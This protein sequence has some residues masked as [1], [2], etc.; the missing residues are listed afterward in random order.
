MKRFIF[1]LLI[2]TINYLFFNCKGPVENNLSEEHV[3]VPPSLQSEMDSVSMVRL[4][5]KEIDELK[6]QTYAVTGN[7]QDYELSAPGVVFPSPEYSS[8]ISSPINGQISQINKREGEWVRKGE[9]LFNIQSLEFGSMVSD[10]LSA[11]AEEQY[12]TNNLERIQQLVK[13]TI[14]SASELE[15]AKAEYQRAVVSAKAAYSKLKAI[16]VSDMEIKSFTESE[17]IN[18]ILK[19]RSPISGIIQQNFVELGQSINALENLSRVLDTRKVLIRGY[20]NPNDARRVKQGDPVTIS[21]REEK[22][23]IIMGT[24]A[25]VNPGLDE[26]SKSVI[27]NIYTSTEDGWP[28]PGENVHLD[29]KTSSEIEIII[30]PIGAITYDGNDAIVFV[31]KSNNIFEKRKIVIDRL[32]DDK[33]F[34]KSGLSKGEK[35]AISQVFSLKALSRMDLNSEE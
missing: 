33:V 4:N 31:E 3:E 26:N 22:D 5:A 2:I 11:F 35:I 29:I 12:Q 32:H 18:P 34:V 28:K 20:L 7:I 23:L 1:F 9:V 8:I 24:V 14:S 19:I 17:N 25:S 30:I 21:K 16:G 6:I 10:Y 15:Q 13:E 27:V